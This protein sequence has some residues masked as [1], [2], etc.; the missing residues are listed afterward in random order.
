MR[1]TRGYSNQGTQAKPLLSIME[2][3][4]TLSCNDII[5]LT[6][7][8]LIVNGQTFNVLFEMGLFITTEVTQSMSTTFILPAM[9][10]YMYVSNQLRP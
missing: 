8:V 7:Y 2:G 3:E 10:V 6:S 1:T 4:K 9:M 5:L